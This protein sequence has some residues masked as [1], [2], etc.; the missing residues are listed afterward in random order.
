MVETLNL[1]SSQAVTSMLQSN[2]I[3]VEIDGSIRRITLDNFMTAIQTGSLDIKQYGWG[4]PLKQNQSSQS[5][6][7][8]G[9]TAMWEA[10][11]SEVGRYLLT[12]DGSK[13]AK[14]SKTNSAYFADGTA[15]NESKGHVMVSGPRLYYDVRADA[16]TG[17]PVL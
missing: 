10:F 6:G 3:L 4:V 15:V 7:R 5:W 17:I 1:G 8:V 2:S 14:L 11:K 12:N 13:M 16:T 9:N